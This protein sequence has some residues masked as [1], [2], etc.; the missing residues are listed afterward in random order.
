MDVVH[1]GDSFVARRSR[2]RLRPGKP[3][4][5]FVPGTEK[6]LA[7]EIAKDCCRA[8]DLLPS[9][10]SSHPRIVLLAG[11]W[12]LPSSFLH[13]CRGMEGKAQRAL[14][15]AS[16]QEVDRWASGGGR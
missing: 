2:G 10:G 13:H 14:E 15:T 9:H 8:R 11:G 3:P 1:K 5:V 12:A 16:A 4:D 7:L 6:A